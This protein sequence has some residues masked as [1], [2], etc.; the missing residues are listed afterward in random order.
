MPDRVE[1]MKRIAE[2]ETEILYGTGAVINARPFRLRLTGNPP[3]S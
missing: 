2:V 1:E 3:A